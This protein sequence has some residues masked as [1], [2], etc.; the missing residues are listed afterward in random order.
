MTPK[1][2]ASGFPVPGHNYMNIS[3]NLAELSTALDQVISDAKKKSSPTKQIQIIPNEVS[4]QKVIEFDKTVAQMDRSEFFDAF[5][6]FAQGR[7]ITKS[8]IASSFGKAA[9]SIYCT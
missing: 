4:I 8:G 6:T 9:K 2:R 7:A 5:F 1:Y 3:G